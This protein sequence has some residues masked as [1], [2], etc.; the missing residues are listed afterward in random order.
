M[1]H[2]V[3]SLHLPISDVTPPELKCPD[4]VLV[5][6]LPDRHYALVNMSTPPAST[7][8]AKIAKQQRKP[9]EYI[10]RLCPFNLGFH[11][12]P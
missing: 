4:D 2:P 3:Q 8:K 10:I 1:K 11:I 6:A 5:E 7:G 12:L 9:H